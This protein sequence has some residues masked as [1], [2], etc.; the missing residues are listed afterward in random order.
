MSNATLRV[1]TWNIRGGV[2]LDRRFD[3]NRIIATLQ[4]AEPDVVALQEVDSR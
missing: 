2:G 1:A 4:R 3:L